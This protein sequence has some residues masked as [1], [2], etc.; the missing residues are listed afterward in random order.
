MV[1][2]QSKKIEDSTAAGKLF[3]SSENSRRDS[4]LLH[5]SSVDTSLQST[6]V[7]TRRS[8]RFSNS[9]NSVKVHGEGYQFKCFVILAVLH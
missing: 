9:S 1:T 6:V 7:N 2:R 5:I 8:T 3:L 4:G